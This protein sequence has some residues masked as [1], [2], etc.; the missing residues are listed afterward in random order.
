MKPIQERAELVFAEGL[1]CVEYRLPHRYQFKRSPFLLSLALRYG[2]VGSAAS[3]FVLE[4]ADHREER[5]LKALFGFWPVMV[6]DHYLEQVAP[7]LP[8]ADSRSSA[9]AVG[10]LSAAPLRL[11]MALRRQLLPLS[12]TLEL[13]SDVYYRDHKNEVGQG[14]WIFGRKQLNATFCQATEDSI[15]YALNFFD[16][17][18]AALEEVREIALFDE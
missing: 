11:A 9:T 14:T 3:L 6:A 16:R 7:N 18:R 1:K 17:R 12:K 2:L 13:A 4:M 15:R 8:F 5:D 10:R